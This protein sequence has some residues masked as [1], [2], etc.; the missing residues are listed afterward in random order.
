MLC[1]IDTSFSNHS[2]IKMALLHY[3]EIVSIL[4]ASLTNYQGDY[5]PTFLI[6]HGLEPTSHLRQT[7]LF[8]SSI[9]ETHETKN[10]K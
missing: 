10:A 5:V 8:D 3:P 4:G 7:L 1:L 2:Y 9:D 6:R